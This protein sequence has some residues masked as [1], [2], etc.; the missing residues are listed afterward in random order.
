MCCDE[1]KD[2]EDIHC[3]KKGD[4]HTNAQQENYTRQDTEENITT[5][6]TKGIEKKEEIR[7]CKQRNARQH[8]PTP[9]DPSERQTRQN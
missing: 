7:K 9:I 3:T 8:K 4:T 5:R 1:R 6:K 2:K